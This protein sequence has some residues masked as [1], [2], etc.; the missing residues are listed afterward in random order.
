[1]SILLAFVLLVTSFAFA[2]AEDEIDDYSTHLENEMEVCSIPVE[3]TIQVGDEVELSEEIVSVD[4]GET[5]PIINDQIIQD[6]LGQEGSVQYDMIVKEDQDDS[7]ITDSDEDLIELQEDDDDTAIPSQDKQS[8]NDQKLSEDTPSEEVS[9]E[10]N[11]ATDITPVVSQNNETNNEQSYQDDSSFKNDVPSSTMLDDESTVVSQKTPEFEAKNEDGSVSMQVADNAPPK[12][13]QVVSMEEDDCAISSAKLISAETSWDGARMVTFTRSTS[14][15]CNIGETIDL[16]YDGD[17]G[18][19]IKT[20]KSYNKRVVSVGELDYN[21]V[22]LTMNKTGR[23]KIKITRTNG[24]KYSL[25]IKVVDPYAPT[26]IE[27]WQYKEKIKKRGT[28]TMPVGE[29]DQLYSFQYKNGQLIDNSQPV[30]WKSSKS[31]VVSINSDGVVSAKR[32][33]KAKITAKTYNGKKTYIYIK[34]VR[35]RLDNIN[36]KPSGR[37]IKR[38]YKNKYGVLLKSVEYSN[39]KLTIEAYVINGTR[40]KATIYG[41]NITL[42]SSEYGT[43][44]NSYFTAKGVK[45]YGSKLIKMS[46]DPGYGG[47]ANCYNQEIVANSGMNVMSRIGKS[48]FGFTLT[49]YLRSTNEKSFPNGSVNEP[50]NGGNSDFFERYNESELKYTQNA[51]HASTSYTEGWTVGTWMMTAGAVTGTIVNCSGSANAYAEADTS[52]KILKSIPLSSQV[53][54]ICTWREWALCSLNDTLCGWIETKYL[55]F[56]PDN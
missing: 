56:K 49:G 23:V 1:M 2:C 42:T 16:H 12:T 22:L 17:D 54:V 15:T 27:I 41:G 3:E 20:V 30:T 14:I 38:N 10:N 40:K 50:F 46:L 45:A 34:V 8:N 39:S 6:N 53:G 36:K 48:H 47:Q 29:T 37:S 25:K 33:G 28:I 55:D 11:E 52:T 26:S 24:K 19:Y 5:A 43:I 31:R 4:D 44:A 32:T 21:S 35:N 13:T 9:K 51:G 18:Y 7:P